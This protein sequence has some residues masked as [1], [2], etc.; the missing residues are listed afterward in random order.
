M[1]FGV[2]IHAILRPGCLPLW[3]MQVTIVAR[4]SHYLRDHIVAESAFL[5]REQVNPY[6]WA[7]D[8]GFRVRRVYIKFKPQRVVVQ[9]S[10]L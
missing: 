3:P 9:T 10:G 1:I 2:H 4:A 8:V 5:S 6:T 7:L